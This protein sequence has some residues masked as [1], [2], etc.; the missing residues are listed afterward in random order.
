MVFSALLW[1]PLL[2]KGEITTNRRN[3]EQIDIRDEVSK[4]P[5]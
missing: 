2:E 4:V 3:N 5:I 1:C